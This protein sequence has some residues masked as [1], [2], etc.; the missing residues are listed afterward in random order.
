MPVAEKFIETMPRSIKRIH[1]KHPAFKESQH[2]P[3][4]EQQVDIAKF[5]T[6]NGLWLVLTYGAD[7]LSLV[8]PWL[9]KGFKWIVK[10]RFKGK[11][12]Q[13]EIGI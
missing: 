1:R 9:G 12:D 6:Y 5:V 10:R 4:V 11:W 13:K 3:T 8:S 2:I 7:L